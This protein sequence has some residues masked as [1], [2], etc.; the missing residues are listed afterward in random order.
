MFNHLKR[1][2]MAEA[3]AATGAAPAAPAADPAPSVP[4]A[5]GATP[6]LSKEM[7]DA[8]ASTI[9]K[10]IAAVRD[11]IFAEARRTFTE[12][13]S[14]SAPETPTAPS[15]TP[16]P[17]DAATERRILRDF[18]RALTRSGLSDKLNAAQ[19][20]RAEKLILEERPED[21]GSWVKDYF[22]GYGSAASPVAPPATQAS[23]TA[24]QRPVS[25]KPISSR[26]SP[27]PTQIALE[28]ID[29]PTASDS[30]RQA[31]IAKK[32]MKAYVE[33]VQ[34]QLKGRPVSAV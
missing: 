34:R 29:L 4:Q 12:K 7:A 17:L 16:Q 33:T 30:D 18:D 11:S 13:R 19:W 25:D 8:I 27:Q 14:K 20:S 15:V 5:Q 21:V 23:I 26:G 31:F 28:E 22:E 10:E 3:D 24:P 6:A 2:L 32:G 1:I 9:A